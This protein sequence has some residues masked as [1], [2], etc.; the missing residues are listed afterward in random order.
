[1]GKLNNHFKQLLIKAVFVL[2]VAFVVFASLGFKGEYKALEMNATSTAVGGGVLKE[3]TNKSNAK[4][5]IYAMSIIKEV[6]GEDVLIE[7]VEVDP[8]MFQDNEFQFVSFETGGSNYIS[9][10][11]PKESNGRKAKG[12][13]QTGIS[14]VD[15]KNFN[16]NYSAYD[17]RT[18]YD[19]N[20]YG[21]TFGIRWYVDMAGIGTVRTFCIDAATQIVN[22]DSFGSGSL[23]GW[24]RLGTWDKNFIYGAM[25]YNMNVLGDSDAGAWATTRLIWEKTNNLRVNSTSWDV[26]GE[27]AQIKVF[28]ERYAND[29]MKPSYTN[30]VYTIRA[31]QPET[32][33]VD[34]SGA[35]ATGYIQLTANGFPSGAYARLYQGNLYLYAPSSTPAGTYTVNV[36]MF[37]VGGVG[38]LKLWVFDGNGI[39]QD[40]VGLKNFFDPMGTFTLNILAAE[41][42][43]KITKQNSKGE[44]V[45]GTVFDFSPNAD[46]SGATR[47]TTGTYGSVS[48]NN[49]LQGTYYYT[50]VSVPAPL[51]VDTTIKSLNVVA[52]ETTEVTVT[53]Q[54]AQGQIEIYKKEDSS[55]VMFVDKF[56][57]NAKYEIRNSQG[58][59]VAT[60][61]TDENGYAKTNPLPLGTYTAKE[62]E[63]PIGY[64]LDPNTYTITLAYAN[65]TTP[66]VTE[67]RN[68]VDKVISGKVR[69]IKSGHSGTILLP[70]AKFGIYEKGTNQLV[71]ELVTNAFGIA[72]SR[73]LRFG[74][75][76]AK[77][78]DAPYGYYVNL[79]TFDFTIDINGELEHILV[80]NQEARAK[81]K[82]KKV[83]AINHEPMANVGFSIADEQMN[84]IEFDVINGTK[85]EKQSVYYT[86]EDGEVLINNYLYVGNYYLVEVDT[87][88]GYEPLAPIPFTIDENQTYIEIPVIGT[89]K[90]FEVVNNRKTATLEVIK[91]DGITKFPLPGFEFN[92]LDSQGFIVETI[93]TG[94]DGKATTT[95]PLLYNETYSVVEVKTGDKYYIVPEDNHV[96]M[97]IDEDIEI[98]GIT[99]QMYYADML[100]YKADEVTLSPLPGALF[101]FIDKA[102]GEI[103][104]EGTTD[105]TGELLVPGLVYNHTYIIHEEKAPEGYFAAEDEEFTLTTDTYT[106]LI[107]KTKTNQFMYADGYVVKVDAVR[108]NES[109]PT[110]VTNKMVE[111]EYI[112]LPGATYELYHIDE[113]VIRTLVDTQTT[114]ENG[115]MLFKDLIKGQKYCLVETIAPEGYFL[116][117][118]EQCFEVTMDSTTFEFVKVVSDHYMYTDMMLIK[119][120]VTSFKV[121]PGAEFNLFHVLKDGT[122]ELIQSG[123]TD[124]NGTIL[125][126]DLIKGDKYH[127]VETK[128]PEGYNATVD[129]Y[130][131]VEM[132][133]TT[134]LFDKV[135]SNAELPKTGL[136]DVTSIVGIGMTVLGFG[137]AIVTSRKKEVEINE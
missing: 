118:Q 86:N 22:G 16:F 43:A 96:E 82:V 14:R 121:L 95:I 17:W 132:E 32:M 27:M 109:I 18:G 19:V 44:A 31:G 106:K 63:A 36:D 15:E 97:Q 89:V 23:E 64:L 78:I 90:D 4:E 53:N 99:N 87:P 113:D 60:L 77:E 114:D 119:K 107:T 28:A 133:S 12:V 122:E 25:L 116:D 131:T 62:I 5:E 35:S 37:G 42:H 76:Y 124:A 1:M 69:V 74:D 105:E 93:T 68:L 81:I 54:F 120:D 110:D 41:G 117:D 46:M 29:Q 84:I 115:S 66:I 79:N 7:N 94:K 21:D 134:F 127:L 2:L 88:F 48:I 9:V 73:D 92:V 56:L 61:I 38:L 47:Y 128:A 57:P 103:V 80:N 59:V 24:D 111:P 49:I 72:E 83:D 98:V 8:Q 71:E 91:T 20:G 39:I 67:T 102:T 6:M 85:V 40:Q 26:S 30:G 129:E 33:I 3:F 130:F 50:E 123:V 70:D 100:L 112:L 45:P 101:Q 126:K 108:K 34:G 52:D 58:T 65:Q 13:N 125:F 137:L 135:V 51:I 55:S 11:D 10:I 75:Y 104:F 136:T